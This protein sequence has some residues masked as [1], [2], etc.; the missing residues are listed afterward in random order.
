MTCQTRDFGSISVQEKDVLEFVLPPFGFEQS[1]HYTLLFPDPGQSSIGFLQSLD[2]PSLCFVLIDGTYFKGYEP[3]LPDKVR[4]QLG[5]GEISTWLVCVVPENAENARVNLRSP[6]VI[7][8]ET[9]RGMQLV[10]T[11]DYPLR[12]PLVLREV[13]A[14]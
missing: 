10:L 1:T 12:H 6:I 13:L 4:N 2:D 8:Q 9:K 3:R 7:N 14:C 11:Q 5:E